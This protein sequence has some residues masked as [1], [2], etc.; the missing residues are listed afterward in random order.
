MARCATRRTGSR[1]NTRSSSR[2]AT[3]RAKRSR[4]RSSVSGRFT[5]ARGATYVLGRSLQTGRVQALRPVSRSRRGRDDRPQRSSRRRPAARGRVALGLGPHAG[6][7]LRVG[8]ARRPR[9]RLAPRSPTRGSS[10]ARTCASGPGCCSHRL[11]DLQHLGARLRAERDAAPMTARLVT[12]RELDGPGR[13]ALPRPRG[14]WPRARP[15]RV[16]QRRRRGGSASALRTCASWDRRRRCSRCRPRSS[17]SSP[18]GARTFATSRSTSCAACSSIWRPRGS[19]PSAT[20]SSWSR[21]A[22]RRARTEMLEAARRRRRRPRPTSSARLVARVRDVD[23]D[24]IENHNLHGF[25]LPFLD[26]SAR[27]R[28]ACRSRS[29]ARRRRDCGSAPRARG[30]ALDERAPATRRAACATSCPGREL[31]DTMDAVRRHDFSDARSAGPRAQGGRA[32]PRPRRR[33]SASYIPRRRDLRRLSHAIPERVRRYA[34]RRRDEVAGARAH[35]R[36]RGVRAR[37]HGAAPLRAPGRRGRRDGRD[38]SAARARVPARGRGAARARGRATARRTAAR[39]CTCSPTGVAHRVVKA[40]V[41][42]LYPSLMRA[43]R[44]GPAR[45]RLGALLALVDRLVEQRLAAKARA[46][47]RRAGLGGAPHARGAVGGDEARRQLGVRL[48]RAP[49]AAHALRRRA[50]RER[51]DAARARDAR[52]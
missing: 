45:D 21:C 37:A 13:A 27:A 5:R 49:A 48:P 50:R 11:D 42:S 41:A 28:S 7:R 43:Y 44:I 17:T 38:R 2:S 35:A 20:A 34:T 47:S 32:A 51:G 14:R 16:L 40:D 1:G 26:R 6:H 4:G 29:A 52:R 33:R 31:I 10:S 15:P 24:V 23:P 12:W 18:R 25:D 3:T 19:T 9:V 30:A 8:G 39:R 22:T 36:R 46:R